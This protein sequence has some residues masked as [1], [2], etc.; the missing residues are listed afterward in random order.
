M[1][2][3]LR[4]PYPFFIAAG[5]ALVVS[6]STQSC[7]SPE[8]EE[9]AA[10]REAL[11][12]GRYREA[13]EHYTEVTLEAPGSPEAAQ[14][15]YDVALIHYLRRRDLD[16]ARSTFRKILDSYPESEVAR[17]ARRVLARMYEQDLGEPEKAIREYELLLESESDPEERRSLLMWIGNCQYTM[18]DL[19]GAA[20]AYHRVVEDAPGEEASVGAYL[21]LAHIQRLTG[22]V[23][24]A[25]A[26][27]DSVL[28]VSEDPDSRRNAYQAQAEMLAEQSRFADA[29]SCLKAAEDEFSND[30]EFAALASRIADQEEERRRA[31]SGEE[32]RSF[33][34]GRGRP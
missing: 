26:N 31:E 18:N 22:H 15:L 34:W 8:S 32:P 6:L 7:S 19:E 21:R 17:D 13:I 14:A 24:E 5:L 20:G 2:F 23:E 29:R 4:R 33:R 9:L 27:L 11:G 12:A 16:A 1:I 3:R 10:A 28:S 30:E 25:L